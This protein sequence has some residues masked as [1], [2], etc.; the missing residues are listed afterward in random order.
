[1][2]L[3]GPAKEHIWE[4]ISDKEVQTIDLQREKPKNGPPC[5]AL[6]ARK[7]VPN[8]DSGGILCAVAECNRTT[9]RSDLRSIQ[10]NFNNYC[11]FLPS[12]IAAW[13]GQFKIHQAA[14]SDKLYDEFKAQP[15]CTVNSKAYKFSSRM[16]SLLQLESLPMLNVLTEVFQND[17]PTLQDIALYFFPSDSTERCRSRKNFNSLFE[18]M[19]AEKLMLRSVTDGVE[20][21]VFTSNELNADSRGTVATVNADAGYFLW[22]VFRRIRTDKGIERLPEMEPADMIGGKEVNEVVDMDV[23]MIGGKEVNEVVD[24]DVPK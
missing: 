15:P 4:N 8:A 17:C 13:R 1:M 5:E 7:S 22:G 2:D 3:I 6:S 16:P 10:E 21:M 12:S 18:L 19:N 14:V 11:K 9:E 24:M 23:D 20:L